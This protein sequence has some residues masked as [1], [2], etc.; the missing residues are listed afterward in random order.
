MDAPKYI[1]TS[2]PVSSEA[3]LCVLEANGTYEQFAQGDY[4]ALVHVAKK[5]NAGDN[6]LPVGPE[7]IVTESV[8][9]EDIQ[10]GDRIL[11]EMEVTRRDSTGRTSHT[12]LIAKPVEGQLWM[13]GDQHA[14]TWGWSMAS[15]QKIERIVSD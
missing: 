10:I 3:F 13:L 9:P 15:A 5:L 8:K 1:V 11:V 7:D 12:H 6:T 14:W 4:Q 2:L